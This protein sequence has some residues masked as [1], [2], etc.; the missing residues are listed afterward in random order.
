[1]RLHVLECA[2]GKRECHRILTYIS[3][4]YKKGHR[5]QPF[6]PRTDNTEIRFS[7]FIF[8]YAYEDALGEAKSRDGFSLVRK[9]S[10]LY[11][12]KLQLQ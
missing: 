4:W 11:A 1:M 7:I 3:T 12:R 6:L 5:T 8:L 2:K 10:A 9:M